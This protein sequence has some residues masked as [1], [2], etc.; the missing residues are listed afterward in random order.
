LILSNKKAVGV[1]R[2]DV[3]QDLPLLELLASSIQHHEVFARRVSIDV[4][5]DAIQI[6]AA[7]QL[8][9]A[10]QRIGHVAQHLRTTCSRST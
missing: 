6:L 5:A 8:T 10:R 9:F 4:A 3:A 1:Q 2:I 7:W